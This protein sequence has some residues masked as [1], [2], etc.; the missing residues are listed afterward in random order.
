MN[1]G[2]YLGVNLTKAVLAGLIVLSMLLS[3][4]TLAQQL[5][6]G[7]ITVINRLDGTI[8]IAQIPTGTVG[9][10]GG[11]VIEQY[12]VQDARLLDAVHAGDRV[13]YVITDRGGVRSITRL[14]RQK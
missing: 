8:A 11:P 7:M 3:S 10:N 13:N 2:L 4:T 9:N 1:L 6:N 12:N 5:K 14:E